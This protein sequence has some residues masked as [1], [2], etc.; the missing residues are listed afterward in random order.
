MISESQIKAA[1]QLEF[2]AHGAIQRIMRPRSR[3]LTT[4]ARRASTMPR[5]GGDASSKERAH[6]RRP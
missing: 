1:I 2:K 4:A 3:A 6:A 5:V